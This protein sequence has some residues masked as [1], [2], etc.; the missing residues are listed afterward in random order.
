MGKYLNLIKSV[1]LFQGFKAD[2]IAAMIK[3]LSPTF[4]V[5]GKDEVIAI[6][7]DKVSTAG[8]II[9]SKANVQKKIS[10]AMR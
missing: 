8:I 10:T 3:C 2:E 4:T 9:D 7:E 6:R 5:Y 1:G